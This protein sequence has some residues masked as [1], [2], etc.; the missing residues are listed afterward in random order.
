[1]VLSGT[2]S[3][4]E[5]EVLQSFL[6]GQGS[7]DELERLGDHIEQCAQCV[8][9]L[10]QLRNSDAL[11]AALQAPTASEEIANPV[12]D[13]LIERLCGLR[14]PS[15]SAT[16][17][18]GGLLARTARPAADVTQEVYD[19]LDP[20]QEPDE[21]G[22]LGPYRVLKV[23]GVG[24][25]SVVFQA[26]EPQLKRC[27]ALKTMKPVLAANP[28]SRRRFL[29]E[30]QATA[31]IEHDH[32]V[33]VL[34]VGEE[35]GLPFLTMPLLRG[36]TLEDR[37][38]REGKLPVA[39]VLRT[40]QEIAEGLAAAHQCN[41]IHRDIKPSN[42][43][44]EGPDSANPQA[45]PW[46]GG[47]VK[48][49][50][51]GLARAIGNE[52]HLTQSGVIVGTPSYM[53]P[54]QARGETLDARCD[55]FSL[56][57]VLY[58]LAT[59]EVP[60]K[61]ASTMATLRAL[62]LDQPRP[63][64]AVN[65]EVPPALSD[66]VLRLL[67]KRPD[68]RL[69]SARAVVEALA[70]LR[71]GGTIPTRPVRR[72]GWPAL[73]V[74]VLLGVLGLLGYSL[75]PGLF[76]PAFSPTDDRPEPRK[77]QASARPCHFGLQTTYPVGTQPY[78]VA[79]GDFNGDGRLDLAVSNIATNTVS[80]LL[81]NGDGTFRKALDQAA[82]PQ[83]HG[84]A[85]AD[86]NGDGKLDLAV[87]YLQGDAV[88]ILLGN[89]DGTFRPA[90]SLGVGKNPR[91]VAVGDFNGDGK[92]DLAVTNY[93]GNSLHVFFGNGDC[94]FRAA[95]TY[96]AG[97]GP[98]SVAVADFNSDG[99]PDLVVSNGD[100]DTVDILLANND[101][102]FRPAVPYSV[103]SGP[104]AVVVADFNGDGHAD[105]A[106]ENYG[107]NDVTVLLGNGDGT[108]RLAGSYGAGSGPGGLA[109]G[110][111]NGDGVPDLVVAN[112]HSYNLSVLL[113]RGDGT[114]RPAS[115]FAAG[116]TPAGV[117]VG[118]FNGDGRTDLAVANHWG[119]NVSVL[120]NRPPAPHFNVTFPVRVTAG[121]SYSLSLSARNASQQAD[122]GYT[123]TVRL[124]SSDPKA[125]LVL[126]RSYSLPTEF[127]FGPE[128]NGVVSQKVLLC[129]AGVQT[130]TVRDTRLPDRAG[131]ITVLV[132]PQPASRLRV[133]VPVRAPAGKEC[134]VTVTAVDQFGNVAHEYQGTVRFSSSDSRAVLPANYRFTLS[135]ES[136][137]R[138]PVTFPAEGDQRLTVTDTATSITGTATVNVAP[139]GIT[140]EKR[141]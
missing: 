82:G 26:E 117:A 79:V 127:S 37:L 107:S 133:S 121:N 100:G 41:I 5:S 91:G 111:F 99:R 141:K 115:H 22:R 40:G 67:A 14:G 85:V 65:P 50:D 104:G 132:Q 113:S 58:R 109:V 81:G 120:L 86:F 11:L 103:G 123:G 4:P 8:A 77:P 10:H 92:A 66:L 61:G 112:H 129:T 88:G 114:F 140:K 59:G 35:R 128:Q 73:A 98:I 51:F 45:T 70:A 72:R 69:P 17:M 1:L 76:R 75:G 84:L 19:F 42:I 124:Q 106:V 34:Q 57:C 44:L 80:V 136:V 2:S 43:F 55:L 23:I 28:S 25:M 97:L 63:P 74:A 32:I 102:T 47:R 118:D 89:G 83:P 64:D 30:A 46:G 13:D 94:T 18:P 38:Q 24:G 62:E 52:A 108:L 130:L 21:I 119:Q 36:K 31:G 49:L 53:A 138:F 29:C 3:C 78:A 101:G 122:T 105:V 125:E 33:A 6:L 68:D 135:D 90:P 131:S 48:I 126:E 134:T 16:V 15:S 139:A 87:A 96:R 7:A 60:F 39:E 27:V 12:V 54:E 116:R 9:T 137:R 110:D 56:G 71:E 93:R 20:P 95:G